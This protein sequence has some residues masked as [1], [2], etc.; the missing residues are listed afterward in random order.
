ML[1][2][3]LSDILTS[4]DGGAPVT[5]VYVV[6]DDDT[7][8]YVGKTIRGAAY[9]L[10]QHLDG[11]PYGSSLGQLVYYNDPA[12][13]SW[14]VD[15]YDPQECGDLIKQYWP[16]YYQWDVD[17][18]EHALIKHLHPCLNCTYNDEPGALPERYNTGATPQD[19]RP[20]AVYTFD[21]SK[22]R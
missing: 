10:Y 8:F 1:T 4:G 14:F 2:F 3:T 22:L 12:S 11:A 15:V 7:V 6:R 13:R 20:P 5:C 19:R 18:V 17:A 16:N 9:R 21:L